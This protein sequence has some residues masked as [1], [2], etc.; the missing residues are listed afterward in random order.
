[1]GDLLNLLSCE[2]EFLLVMLASPVLAIA[3]PNQ[4]SRPSVQTVSFN[5]NKVEVLC[6]QLVDVTQLLITQFFPFGGKIKVNIDDRVFR[7]NSHDF[8][9]YFQKLV[10]HTSG[11]CRCGE[12]P[13]TAPRFCA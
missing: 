13:Q 5:F 9:F 2:N 11:K 10:V 1:M 6:E 12:T 4:E 8:F 3:M 7:R